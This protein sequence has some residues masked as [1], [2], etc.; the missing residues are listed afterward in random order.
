MICTLKYWGEGE[1]SAEMTTVYFQMDP[2]KHGLM[3]G[4][5]DG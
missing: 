4:L 1:G 3:D 2:K 5:R